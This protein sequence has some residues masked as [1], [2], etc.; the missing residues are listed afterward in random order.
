L[1]LSSLG[2]L[3][4]GNA[5]YDFQL[6]QW[7][8]TSLP[9]TLPNPQEKDRAAMALFFSGTDNAG[10]DLSLH[11]AHVLNQRLYPVEDV[12][13]FSFSAV[14]T[15]LDPKTG[16]HIPESDV[17][18]PFLPTSYLMGKSGAPWVSA[19][20][21]TVDAGWQPN[22]G[23]VPLAS[24][25]FPFGEPHTAFAGAPT[26]GV[27]QVMPVEHMDHLGVSGGFYNQN[28]GGLRQFY[29]THLARLEALLSSD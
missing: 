3:P 22:D 12:Y 2:N 20:G 25:L 4:L 21:V 24:A 8:L 9:L 5:V 11:G 29:A 19:D 17:F 13:Y 6:E 27:W 7:G 15:K 28:R 23:L 18:F 14:K 26:P 10:F 16:D 1:A